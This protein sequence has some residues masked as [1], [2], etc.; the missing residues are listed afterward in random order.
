MV[1]WSNILLAL[2][3][4]VNVVYVGKFANSLRY[5]GAVWSYWDFIW[6]AIYAFVLYKCY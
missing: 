3:V 4:G 1:Y 2:L 5:E 6:M